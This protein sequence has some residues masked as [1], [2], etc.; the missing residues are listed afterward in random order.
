MA[1]RECLEQE[2]A[3][4]KGVESVVGNKEECAQCWEHTEKDNGGKN[5]WNKG[6]AGKGYGRRG[7]STRGNRKRMHGAGES[8]GGR[9][10]GEQG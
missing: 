6:S 10:A 9:V 1:G 4:G 7:Y 8:K 2:G 3:E 5:M